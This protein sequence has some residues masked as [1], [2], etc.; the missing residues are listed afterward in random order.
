[1]FSSSTN[2]LPS[3]ATGYAKLDYRRGEVV[4]VRV[5]GVGP[6]EGLARRGARG[7]LPAMPVRT[8]AS[9]ASDI[10]VMT[11]TTETTERTGISDISVRT[12]KTTGEGGPPRWGWVVPVPPP[13]PPPHD[14]Q[15]VL[16]AYPCTVRSS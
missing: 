13:L 10:S 6:V 5:V 2:D 1:M 3:F 8:E 14:F 4:G 9:E 15:L 12:E 16:V 11:E 7:I